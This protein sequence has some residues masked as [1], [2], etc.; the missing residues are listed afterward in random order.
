[1]IKISKPLIFPRRVSIIKKAHHNLSMQITHPLTRFLWLI[2]AFV[3]SYCFTQ[4]ATYNVSDAAELAVAI[5][6]VNAG[7]ENDTVVLTADIELDAVLPEINK[8]SGELT[9]EGGSYTLN[10]NAGAG[11][12]FRV[13]TVTNGVVVIENLTISG[14]QTPEIGELIEQ[15][16]GGIYIDSGTL[17]LTNCTVSGNSAADW[18]GGIFS[19][20]TVIL[21]NCTVSNNSARQGG[22]GID[23]RNGTMTLTNCTVSNNT[24][25]YG[26]GGIDHRNG[27]MTLTNCTVSGNSAESLGGGIVNSNNGTMTL[28]NCTVSG[29]SARQGGGIDNNINGTM[30]LT[31]CTVS[32]NSSNSGYGGGIMNIHT[33]TLTN[34]T[35]SDNLANFG[36][37]ILLNGGTLTMTRN[38][39]AGN[40]APSGAEI[41]HLSGTINVNNHNVFGNSGLNNAAAF[42]NFAPGVSDVNCT[43]DGTIPSALSSILV[44]TLADNGGPTFTHALAAGSPAIDI[45]AEGPSTDQRGVARPVGA[46]YDAGAVEFVPDPEVEE[47]DPAPTAVF[48]EYWHTVT[49]NTITVRNWN[50]DPNGILGTVPCTASHRVPFPVV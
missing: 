30:I 2:T 9:I 28:T 29:N 27:T 4:A 13:L 24:A 22:G 19:F 11:T 40:S 36:G 41:S 15:R 35:V 7:G 37:G 33:M 16:G 34:C 45:A 12:A 6:T 38:I 44:S 31:N 3:F 8:A 14:G 42:S 50:L 23:H 43:S 47:G 49:S 10:R 20:G 46:R 18:G 32:G 21:T 17:T 1:L 48:E 26:G 5:T 25:G 39:I